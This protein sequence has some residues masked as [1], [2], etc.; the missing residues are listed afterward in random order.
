MNA[1]LTSTQRNSLAILASLYGSEIGHKPRGVRR[2]TIQV[3]AR[4]GLIDRK[5]HTVGRIETLRVT[6]AGLAA[7]SETEANR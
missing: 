6:E 7:I 3:L 5:W 2:D 4:L 1:T